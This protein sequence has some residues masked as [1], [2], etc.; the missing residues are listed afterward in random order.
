MTK[1]EWM[2]KYY[3]VPA[4]KATGSDIEAT[5]H[6]LR[7]WEGFLADPDADYVSIGHRTCA[8]CRRYDDGSARE[9]ISPECDKCPLV[10]SGHGIC[11]LDDGNAY[12]E[13]LKDDFTFN[14]IPMI[15]ALRDTLDKLKKGEI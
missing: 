13:C 5:A 6:S 3:P 11:A 15:E 9:L 7:K 12:D 8:L 14:P 2:E 10:R 4:D 1:D